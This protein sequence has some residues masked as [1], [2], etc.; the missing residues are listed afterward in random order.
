MKILLGG[1]CGR[2]GREVAALCAVG[3]HGAILVGG[4]DKAAVG[5]EIVPCAACYDEAEA[6][7]AECIIDFSH[8]TAT[9][10]LLAFAVKHT[11]PLVLATT[12]HTAEE[13]EQ[14]RRAAEMIPLLQ[15][16]NC[17]LG[18]VLM[19]KLVKE[20]V[21][22]LPEADVEIVET[23]HTAKADAPSGTALALADAV[24][25]VRPGAS[26]LCGRTGRRGEKEIGIH[27]LRLGGA[28]GT[29]EVILGTSAQTLTI[30][31]EA[32]SRALFAEGALAAAEFLIGRPAGLYG[33][34]D[35]LGS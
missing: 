27:S 22:A 7:G 15:T 24:R 16:A 1:L 31:H 11:L 35:L 4:V 17:S 6:A 29:H 13:R 30:R 19:Q 20:A 8:H 10:A 3:V 34:A 32:H 23:H 9:T 28:V 26:L 12:G 21:R 25:E 14:I 2:M 18:T 5:A 33:M